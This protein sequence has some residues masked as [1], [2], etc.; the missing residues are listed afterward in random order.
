M[1]YVGDLKTSHVKAT[2]LRL[3][4]NNSIQYIDS[5]EKYNSYRLNN[6]TSLERDYMIFKFN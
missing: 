6:L 4:D 1:W 3:S 5:F 2:T